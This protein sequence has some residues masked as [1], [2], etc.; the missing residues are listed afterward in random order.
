[1]TSLRQRITK[2]KNTPNEKDSSDSTPVQ[3]I[4]ELV[5]VKQSEGLIKPSRNPRLNSR[6]SSRDS[7]TSSN[8]GPTQPLMPLH[9]RGCS[10]PAI[11][12]LASH[13]LISS[14]PVTPQVQ[15]IVRDRSASPRPESSAAGPSRLREP[16]CAAAYD[17]TSLYTSS[18]RQPMGSESTNESLAVKELVSI[19]K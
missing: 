6:Q 10:V 2:G 12:L 11:S 1:M 14:Q 7:G 3:N 18:D 5:I 15:A 17:L 19:S 9:Q 13:R 4:S 8:D 16:D